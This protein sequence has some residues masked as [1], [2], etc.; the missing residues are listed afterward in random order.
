MNLLESVF[1]YYVVEGKPIPDE[2]I[3]S[4][5][6]LADIK[7]VKGKLNQVIYIAK[8]LTFMKMFPLWEQSLMYWRLVTSIEA[9]LEEYKCTS[10]SVYT[11]C[12]MA[13][14]DYPMKKNRKLCRGTIKKYSEV[15]AEMIYG[16]I[17]V[18]VEF[19][20]RIVYANSGRVVCRCVYEI[21]NSRVSVR[22][23]CLSHKLY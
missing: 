16:E 19:M 8:V 9:H 20:K 2:E 17:D 4:F 7:S 10:D 12:R 13:N 23:K 14:S 21:S 5:I 15:I 22:C 18:S 1:Y 11:W 6:G 3:I